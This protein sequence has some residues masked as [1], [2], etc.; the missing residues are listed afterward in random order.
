MVVISP[1]GDTTTRPGGRSMRPP[2]ILKQL[3]VQLMDRAKDEGVSLVG[4]GGLL[5]GPTKT[6]L[7]SALDGELTKHLGSVAHGPYWT[8]AFSVYYWLLGNEWAVL[9]V[10]GGGQLATVER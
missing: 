10:V 1:A 2:P 4:P 6:L 9:C 8:F 5:A 7:E 3:A